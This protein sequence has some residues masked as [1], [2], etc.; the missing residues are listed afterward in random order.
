MKRRTEQAMKF[1]PCSYAPLVAVSTLN[2]PLLCV[3]SPPDTPPRADGGTV[4]RKI[5]AHQYL[6]ATLHK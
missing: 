2:L 5:K 6:I 3:V 1:V 4:N